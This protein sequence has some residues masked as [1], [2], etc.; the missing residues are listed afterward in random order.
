[1]G[2]AGQTYFPQEDIDDFRAAAGLSATK[3]NMVCISTA[4]CTALAGESVGDIGEA[5][6]DVE[7]S[8]GIAKD[9]TVDFV[10]AERR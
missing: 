2:I 5:D 10:Y 8:G 9:A 4:D 1:M 7:W 6:L 3:L